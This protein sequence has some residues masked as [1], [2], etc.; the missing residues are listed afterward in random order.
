MKKEYKYPAIRIH[1]V[2][3]A[4]IITTSDI[5]FGEDVEEGSTDAP[6]RGEGWQGYDE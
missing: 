3:A 4:N 6:R 1:D 5:P 2:K